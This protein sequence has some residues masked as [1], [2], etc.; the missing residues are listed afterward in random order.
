VFPNLCVPIW[1]PYSRVLPEQLTD[2]QLLKKL[3][4]LYGNR[5]FIT[6]FTR[7]RDLA[8]SWASLIPRLLTIF[9]NMIKWGVVSTSL[10][11]QAGGPPLV[12][13]PR[14]LIQYIR[15]YHPYLEVAF[16]SVS[17][18]RAM[19]WWLGP[20]YHGMCSHVSLK[21]CFLYLRVSLQFRT[22]VY[23]DEILRESIYT[24][25][26]Q[27]HQRHFNVA[28]HSVF[29]T[30]DVSPSGSKPFPAPTLNVGR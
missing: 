12:G 13:C 15:S 25:Y 27:F 7:A 23:I 2:P 20:T 18:G 14:L 6:V 22:H 4:A 21:N 19:P 5:R 29:V 28:G 24:E 9:R 30:C 11:P 17:W 1:T 8:L 10:N 3:P 26:F 16:P